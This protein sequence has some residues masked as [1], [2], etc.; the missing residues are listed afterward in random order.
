MLVAALLEIKVRLLFPGEL[1]DLEE[2]TPEQAEAELFQRLIEYHRFQGAAGWLRERAAEG[3]AR[4]PR[5]GR[6]RWRR[7]PNRP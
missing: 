1:D 6:H 2:L 3:A 5:S 4:V 7:A